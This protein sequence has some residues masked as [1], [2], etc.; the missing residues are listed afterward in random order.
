M[1]PAAT[2]AR[3]STDRLQCNCG[4][5][6]APRV[7]VRNMGRSKSYRSKCPGCRKMSDA[8][9]YADKIVDRW[10]EVAIK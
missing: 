4:T 6:L 3:P 1:T 10:N 8:T 5:K 7:I 9:F 2:L